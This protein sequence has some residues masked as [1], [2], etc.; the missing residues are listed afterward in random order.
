LVPKRQKL[1]I[2][3]EQL[4]IDYVSTTDLLADSKIT[5]D[6]DCTEP[7]TP[8]VPKT[9][10]IPLN[11]TAKKKLEKANKLARSYLL[12]NMSN[13]LFNLLSQMNLGV[14]RLA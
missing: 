3:F 1:L 6:A 14:D 8:T 10:S 4:E 13:L 2:C 5:V 11:D 7:C 12:K 9:P